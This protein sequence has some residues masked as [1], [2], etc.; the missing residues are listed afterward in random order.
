MYSNSGFYSFEETN[1]GINWYNLTLSNL[2]NLEELKD[3]HI[4]KN[5][6]SNNN[7]NFTVLYLT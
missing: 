1:S 3:R 7:I 6:I 5:Y 4:I 2:I